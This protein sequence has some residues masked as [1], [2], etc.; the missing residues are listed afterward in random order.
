MK[1]YLPALTLFCLS[2]MLALPAAP[3]PSAAERPV[4]YVPFGVYWPWERTGGIARNAGQDV[5]AFTQ[6][7]C[8][9]LKKSGVDT[10][11]TVN[12]GLEDAKKLLKITRPLGLRLLP[13]LGEI[14][15]RNLGGTAGTKPDDA[16]FMDR[17]SAYYRKAVPRIV[18]E[19]GEDREG[20][21]A[22]VLGDE[23]TGKG[24]ALLETMRQLF[25]AADPQRPVVTVSMWGQTPQ[26]IRETRLQTFCVDLY[27]FFG[28]G[29]PNGPHT[30]EAS[31]NFFTFNAER[32]VE[33]AGKD[34]RTG[35]VMP[36][37]YNEIWG[38]WDL[39]PSGLSVAL[40][41]S[42]IHWRTPTL[43]EI[44]WQIWESL[45][46]GAK[47]VLFFV[48]LGPDRGSPKAAPVREPSVQSV[49]VK[50]P[51][52]ASY[53]ALLDHK[54]RPT[55]QY[56]LMAAIFRRLAP[57]KPLIHRMRPVKAGWLSAG[58]DVQVSN[59]ADPDN[60][61]QYAVIVNPDLA[62]PRIAEVIAGPGVKGLADVLRGEP[63]EMQSL[64]WAGG[65]YRVS[66]PLQAGEGIL[67]K[68]VR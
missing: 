67:I 10:I 65:N 53:P 9:L 23:P 6:A 36:Q 56:N 46:V 33:E 39:R 42:H 26:L 31:R 38:P 43:P 8:Q 15:P 49:L 63:I 51:T 25:L 61:G 54:G 3:A 59:F 13:C 17:A 68:I 57:H 35:W 55:A 2:A 14:E 18:Q 16:D 22:W 64:G 5:W 37:C 66:I 4:G 28:P 24:I 62:A 21:L 1:R 32:M 44:R 41:G 29:S 60:E 30:P 34:G 52:P 40:P 48:F 27:P 50:T 12:I 58:K 11:W 47:G 20:I 19:M 45:R 7:T